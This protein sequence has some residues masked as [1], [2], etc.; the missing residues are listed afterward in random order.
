MLMRWQ[1]CQRNTPH[2]SYQDYTKER[3]VCMSYTKVKERM[4]FSKDF[5]F[6]IILYR[7]FF[8]LSAPFLKNLNC[9]R[10]IIHKFN[11][12]AYICT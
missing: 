10:Q 8:D 9:K 5:A 3:K 11:E 7:A 4:I 12:F 1:S 6:V 2:K